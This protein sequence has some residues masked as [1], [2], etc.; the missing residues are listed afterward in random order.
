M[1]LHSLGV[2]QVLSSDFTDLALEVLGAMKPLSII[3]SRLP[4][5]K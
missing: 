3:S 5:R 2:E 4:G 1:A